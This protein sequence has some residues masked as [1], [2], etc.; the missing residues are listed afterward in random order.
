[1]QNDRTKYDKAKVL[2]SRSFFFSEEK[3]MRWFK[4]QSIAEKKFVKGSESLCQSKRIT[5]DTA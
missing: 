1:M 3:I 5:L 4:E 2:H